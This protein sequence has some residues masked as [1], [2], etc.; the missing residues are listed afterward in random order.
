MVEPGLRGPE[1]DAES[2][3]HLGQRQPEVVM[4]DEDGALLEGQPP[5]GALELVAVVDGEDARA[6]RRLVDRT[7]VRMSAD[8]RR[9]TPGLG[10]ALVGQDPMEPGLEAVGI[11]KRSQLAPGDDERGLHRVLGQVGV[12]Q[13]PARDRHAPIADHAG[14][15]VEGLVVAPLRLVHERSMHPFSPSLRP[16]HVDRSHGRGVQCGRRFNLRGCAP[17]RAARRGGRAARPGC[18]S[19]S[20]RGRGRTTGR[21]PSR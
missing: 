17:D 3:G 19:T 20:G 2:I 18:R 6:A 16:V 15:G 13:D 12:A 7:G 4:E 11:A 21:R 1:W 14:K 9:A 10:V 5:E 8:Q